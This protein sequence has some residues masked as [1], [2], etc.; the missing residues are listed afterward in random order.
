L[1]LS[2]IGKFGIIFLAKSGENTFVRRSCF[3]SSGVASRFSCYD[4]I[5]LWEV[6]MG[7]RTLNLVVAHMNAPCG[8]VLTREHLESVLKAG[9]LEVLGDNERVK[10]LVY[11]LFV[12]NAPMLIVKSAREA[13]SGAVLAN[14]LYEEIIRL[15]HRRVPEWEE[16]V[17]YL[18]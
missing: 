6:K 17:R 2:S 11:Y 1:H 13:G 7:S 9:T 4:E 14:K 18:I 15:G 8:P 5:I 10:S 3:A 16:S 12:E